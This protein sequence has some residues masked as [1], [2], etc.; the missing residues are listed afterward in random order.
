MI[1]EQLR[2]LMKQFLEDGD[3]PIQHIEEDGI[4]DTLN[5]FFTSHKINY[6]TSFDDMFD[7]CG[8]DCWSYSIA[9]IE[10]EKPEIEVYRVVNY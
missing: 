8:F 5:K 10:N 7:S 6:V 1:K 9:W 4:E 3:I 2:D